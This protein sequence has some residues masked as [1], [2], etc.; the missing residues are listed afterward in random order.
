MRPL[1]RGFARVRGVV[2]LALAALV[3]VLFQQ[4]ASA[5]TDVLVVLEPLEQNTILTSEVV[6]RAVGTRRVHD[7]VVRN[8]DGSAVAGFLTADRRAGLVGAIT[9]LPLEKDQPLLRSVLLQPGGDN[10]AAF[11]LS[12]RLRRPDHTL[13]PLRAEAPNIAGAGSV[14]AG[15]LVDI[16][17]HWVLAHEPAPSAT[18]T[19]GLAR[20]EER[21]ARVV[22]KAPVVAYST[23]DRVLT[24]EVDRA[25]ASLLT[26][27]AQGGGKIV[28]APVRVDAPADAE[29]DSVDALAVRRYFGLLDPAR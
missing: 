3:A 11:G 1:E 13:Y 6:A 17:A 20:R 10:R 27:L 28:V 21:A 15:E 19:A 7:S 25:Q 12:A 23:R 2:V 14:R 9:L 26:F 18:P 4:Q 8:A 22:E 29:P 16:Y 5:A 24:V